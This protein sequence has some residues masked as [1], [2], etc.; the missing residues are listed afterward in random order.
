MFFARSQF[1][2]LLMRSVDLKINARVT[3]LTFCTAQSVDR[4]GGSN[5]EDEADGWLYAP[6]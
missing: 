6:L 4:K 3:R 2:P 5:P 1:A